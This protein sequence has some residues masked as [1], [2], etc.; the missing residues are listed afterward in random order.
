MK[1]GFITIAMGKS[2]IM[3]LQLMYPEL[4]I[5]PWFRG[6]ILSQ[7]IIFR[8]TCDAYWRACIRKI[9]KLGA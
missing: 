8:N 1:R 9:R 6:Q 7:L 5:L 4:F 3:R 2:I